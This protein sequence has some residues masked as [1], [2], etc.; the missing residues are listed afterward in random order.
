ML[1][2]YSKLITQNTRSG[3]AQSMLYA[4][5]MTKKDLAKPQ[6]GIGSIIYDS[7]PC[8]AKLDILSNHVKENFKKSKYYPFKFSS[9]GV[10]DGISMGTPGM[11]YSLPSRELIANSFETIVNAH[12]YDGLVCI[13]GCDKNLPGVLM[14]MCRLDR[15]SFIIYGG[16]MPPSCVNGEETDI[17][18][19]FESYGELVS[20]KITEE[21][22]EHKIENCCNKIGGSCSGLYTANTMAS[23]FEVM[24]LTLPNSSSY[25]AN[26]PEK[27]R[28]CYFSY[29]VINK[30]MKSNLTPRKILNKT[31]FVNAI[32]MLYCTGGSTNAIIHL[33]AIAN[34]LDINFT[35]DEFNKY[36]D[37]PVLLN[38]KPH[39]EHMMY[40]L[41]KVGGMSI[42][43]HYLIECGIID[44]SQITITGKT[45]EENVKEY[46]KNNYYIK[47]YDDLK[48]KIN[49]QNVITTIEKPFKESNHIKVLKGNIAK[50]G[51][52]SKIYND[53]ECYRG[54]VVIFNSEDKMIEALNNNKIKKDNI[55]IIRGQ[56]ETTGCPEMLRP[57]S[58]LIGYFGDE[59]PPLLTDGRFSGGSRGILVAH[60]DDMYKNGSITG[61][62]I[63][64]DIIKIDTANNI[65]NLEISEDELKYRERFRH[66]IT[67]PKFNNG[68]LKTYSKYV[69]D[70]DKGF[71]IE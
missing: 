71:I 34:E 46:N 41:H 9:V 31:S 39:G 4:L 10:S 43:I 69:G 6:I 63:N 17:V 38:M 28:E 45:L 5:N 13:P 66:S 42:F 51:C 19:A 2:K 47:N 15:P 23:L 22:Y 62:I 59:A 32:K 30:C 24:G 40:H 54:S 29:N 53:N 64:D 21:E 36:T 37:I 3:A 60:L 7:N 52:I 65:I 27:F 70:I 55:I 50:N 33:L 61:L 8:N 14:A 44:G 68:Y 48:Y 49:K 26:S 12:S 56:G 20:N 1:N 25:P 58:A 57:T 67:R 35:I 11:K 18:T 16:S